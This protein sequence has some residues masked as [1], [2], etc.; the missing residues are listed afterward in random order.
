MTNSRIPVSIGDFTGLHMKKIESNTV[1][2]A[3]DFDNTFID[4][5]SLFPFLVY[6]QGWIKTIFYLIALIPSFIKYL[7]GGMTRQQIKESVLTRFFRG[8]GIIDA[9]SFAKKFADEK[10]DHFIKK[11]AL[12]CFLWHKSQ[13]HRC[14]LV[15]AS[16]E[17]Y[18][19]PWAS[20]QGF[21]EVIASRLDLTEKGVITGKLSGFNCWGP[22]KVYRLI[23]Y[24][25]PK[26]NYQLYAY[27]DSEGDHEMLN[28]AD[29]HFYRTFPH[30]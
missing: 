7:T 26:E 11:E 21:E 9:E 17:L 6:R 3:F 16:L 24:L 27:G 30:R 12:E 29:F 20:R 19:K 25:G 14:L 18:L 1:V 2:A 13:G 8:E 10:L 4:R 28:F 23:A 5:D 22:Q 15:S